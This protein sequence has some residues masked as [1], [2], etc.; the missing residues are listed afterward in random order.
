MSA[1]RLEGEVGTDW[2]VKPK[3]FRFEETGDT[4]RPTNDILCGGKMGELLYKGGQHPCHQVLLRQRSSAAVSEPMGWHEMRNRR[5]NL[6]FE[7]DLVCAVVFEMCEMKATDIELNPG[8]YKSRR[9]SSAS[10][11][12]LGKVMKKKSCSCGLCASFSGPAQ[13]L[14]KYGHFQPADAKYWPKKSV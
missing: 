14:S 8:G 3:A 13:S 12:L 7:S 6:T 1:F 9:S 11:T 10:C 2:G 5:E 4:G